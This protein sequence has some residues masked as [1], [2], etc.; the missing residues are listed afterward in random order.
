M[1]GLY[2]RLTQ[3]GIDGRGAGRVDSEYALV[4]LYG[5][6]INPST[7]VWNVN[8]VVQALNEELASNYDDPLTQDAIDDLQAISS[9]LATKASGS[10][11]HDYRT[12]MYCAFTAVTRPNPS[13]PS[14]GKI[15]EAKWRS[16]L[17]I[18]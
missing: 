15:T 16:D 8:A 17:E 18:A 11:R 10:D 6:A 9:V 3:G 14:L 13:N 7:S 2:D 5:T 4:G 12:K 1:A